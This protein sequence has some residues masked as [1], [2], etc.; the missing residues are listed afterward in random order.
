MQASSAGSSTV[1]SQSTLP[2]MQMARSPT[3][4]QGGLA[5][6]AAPESSPESARRAASRETR[7]PSSP[8][9]P[10]SVNANAK[11]ATATYGDCGGREGDC[12]LLHHACS[13]V[14]AG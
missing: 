1:S 6:S 12:P 7:D 10:E 4:S 3:S 14:P 9:S 8:S 11:P 5:Q 2:S 13:F